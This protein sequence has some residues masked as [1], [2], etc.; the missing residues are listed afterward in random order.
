MGTQYYVVIK[1]ATRSVRRAI[2]PFSVVMH[3]ITEKRI[4][5]RT[6]I[7]PITRQ[8]AF[9]TC[10]AKA[11]NRDT[12]PGVLCRSMRKIRLVIFD[13]GGTVIEDNGEV[14][15]AFYAALEGN[16]LRA[17][18]AELTEF[19]GAS[20][21]AVIT[22]FVE[23]Q[24]GK[25]EPGNE[26]R[27]AKAYQDFRAQLESSFSNGGVKPIRGAAAT[28]DWLRTQGIVCATTTGFYRA[29]TDR[30]LSAAGWQDTFGAN[31]CSDDVKTGR[32][33]PYMIFRAM[34]TTGVDDV[35]EVLNVGDTRLDLQAGNRAGV[36]GVI[37]VL[38]GIHKEDRL[39]PESPSHLIASVADLPA[40]IEAHYS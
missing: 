39:R 13:I 3:V 25:E 16:G 40:L 36:L 21:R 4:H 5:N 27:I 2:F 19:K 23:R 35:R 9:F 24:W 1:M 20:K 32:P 37:G 31:I 34:E 10:T 8:D 12:H 29:V 30:I 15:D 7:I 11:E 22:R 17:S 18:R 28:F 38:T 33:A 14:V 26:A 6:R